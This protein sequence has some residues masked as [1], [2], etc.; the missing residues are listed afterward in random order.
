MKGFS[1]CSIFRKFYSTDTPQM[2]WRV[3]EV[4]YGVSLSKPRPKSVPD[5]YILKSKPSP[6]TLNLT[7]TKHW[8]WAVLPLT[9]D[10]CI[11]RKSC[12]TIHQA[13]NLSELV[14]L[15]LPD[16]VAHISVSSSLTEDITLS[17]SLETQASLVPIHVTHQF[18]L[19]SLHKASKNWQIHL[20]IWMY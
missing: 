3:E 8:H 12:R 10:F 5:H 15:D 11:F 1:C 7:S 20:R 4:R 14:S 17:G 19:M 9:D 16:L 13:P 2:A 6:L 18:R